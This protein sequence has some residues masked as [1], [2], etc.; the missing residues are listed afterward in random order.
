MQI[1]IIKNQSFL[2][3]SLLELNENVRNF[4]CGTATC[5]FITDSGEF[6]DEYILF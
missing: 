5:T 1:N 2:I 3:R 6:V 4:Q